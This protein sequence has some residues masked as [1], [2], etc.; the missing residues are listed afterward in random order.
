MC[1]KCGMA[2]PAPKKASNSGK[3]CILLENMLTRKE[4]VIGEL[5]AKGDDITSIAE[6]LRT[7][8]QTV[9]N[10]LNVIYKKLCITRGS[11]WVIFACKVFA[12]TMEREAEEIRASGYPCGRRLPEILTKREMV[13]VRC[14]AGGMA[15][16]DIAHEMN[17]SEQVVKNYICAITRKLG[18]S[19][20]LEVAL[21]FHYE[22][23]YASRG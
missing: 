7:S 23:F 3:P 10:C 22:E 14:I 13:I 6:K 8:R 16:K 17:I 11:K 1:K 21:R 18:F 2:L 19:D 9:K 15:N 5:L 4:M 20:R 12:E